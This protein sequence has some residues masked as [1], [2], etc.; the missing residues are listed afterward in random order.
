MATN[1]GSSESGV[2]NAPRDGADSIPA[3]HA[4]PV[5]EVVARIGTSSEGLSA[6]EASR[7]LTEF[8]PNEL[9]HAAQAG[10][11]QVLLGQFKS[12]IVWLLVGAATR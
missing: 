6:E 5:A 2:T 11:V 4:M 1:P 12:F 10:F 3:W 7:R 9:R 8:G